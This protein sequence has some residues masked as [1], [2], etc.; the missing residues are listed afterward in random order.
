MKENFFIMIRSLDKAKTIFERC[1]KAKQDGA[2]VSTIAITS[3]SHQTMLYLHCFS[4]QLLCSFHL[5]I[6]FKKI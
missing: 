4:Y 1:N 2:I 6:S 3:I 5:L